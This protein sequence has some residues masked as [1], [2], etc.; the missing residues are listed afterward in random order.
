MKAI[1]NLIRNT[2][3]TVLLTSSWSCAFGYD[4]LPEGHFICP[5]DHRLTLAA[6]VDAQG[7][8]SYQQQVATAI[9]QGACQVGRDYSIG[10]SG[11]QTIETP[12]HNHFVCFRTFDPIDQKEMGNFCAESPT[13]KNL[14]K[15]LKARSGTFTL[16]K[17]GPNM[18]KATCDE[19]GT[20]IVVKNGDAWERL[21]LVFPQP[22]AQPTRLVAK[23]RDQVIKEG[24]QGEDYK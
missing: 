14:E 1:S 3:A 2:F 13:V 17:D 24:C 12:N 4:F 19:G 9:T 6:I 8:S 20:V 7:T 5:Y 18:A 15:E 23:D 21:S 11:L 22:L 16:A 10:V